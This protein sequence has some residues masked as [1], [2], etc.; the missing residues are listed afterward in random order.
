MTRTLAGGGALAAGPARGGGAVRGGGGRRAGGGARVALADGACAGVQLGLGRL[1]GSDGPRCR[2]PARLLCSAASCVQGWPPGAPSRRQRG[3]APGGRQPARRGQPVGHAVDGAGEGVGDQQGAVQQL[4]ER[5]GATCSG[6]PGARISGAL[7][8]VGAGG[9]GGCLLKRGSWNVG[10][11]GGKVGEV[12]LAVAAACGPRRIAPA[13]AAPEL[14]RSRSPHL[15]LSGMS[16]FSRKPVMK[17]SNWDTVP[18]S[19]CRR[20]M[21]TL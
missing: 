5:H 6:G 9:Q 19:L 18:F 13:A 14:A 15:L 12:A 11:Q 16:C 10:R 21:T 1:A 7:L 2:R 3:R 4:Q 20:S 8:P 17:S